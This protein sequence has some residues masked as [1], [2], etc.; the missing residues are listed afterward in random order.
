MGGHGKGDNRVVRGF[1]KV[2]IG[3]VIFEEFAGVYSRFELQSLYNERKK[4]PPP[5]RSGLYYS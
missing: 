5:E 3:W 1:S 2:A 4:R